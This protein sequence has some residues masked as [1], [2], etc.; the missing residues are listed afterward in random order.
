V[1]EGIESETLLQKVTALGFS[2]AQGFHIGRPA[3]LMGLRSACSV[4]PTD[5]AQGISS[6][7]TTSAQLV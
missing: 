4:P 5:S 1:A 6:A 7:A 3:A 2:H